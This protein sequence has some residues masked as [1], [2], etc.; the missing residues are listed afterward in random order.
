M[1][2]GSP[3]R[4]AVVTL[5]LGLLVAL[6]FALGASGPAAATMNAPS[7]TTGDFWTW[8]WT[9]GGVTSV[10]TWTVMEHAPAAIGTNTYDAWHVNE[11][12]RRT[13]SSGSSTTWNDLWLRPSDLGLVKEV[14]GGG[15]QSF[16]WDPPLSQAEF[17]LQGNSWSKTTT[18]THTTPA[19]STPRTI[20]Y[21][22]TALAEAEATVPKGT[23]RVVP[24]RSPTSG[25]TYV[26]SN[27]SEDAGNF[28]EIQSFVLGGLVSDAVL[29]DYRYQAPGWTLFLWLIGGFVALGGV[30]V[31]VLLILRRRHRAW[32]RAARPAV[33]RPREPPRP[34]QGGPPGM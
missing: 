12:V 15:A 23:F 25:S 8:T 1:P 29:T 26:V 16:T 18:L 33:L 2:G 13:T 20:T 27:Y 34:P 9:S 30:S 21:S 31:A 3:I 32:S 28:V 7:W 11:T 19:G 22:G 6:A 4:R 10:R 5:A 17:P 14:L 24:I